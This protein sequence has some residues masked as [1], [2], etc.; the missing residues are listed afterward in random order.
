MRR[1]S[2]N[3]AHTARMTRMS[4]AILKFPGA[5][6]A[7]RTLAVVLATLHTQAD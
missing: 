1:L 6:T 5:C 7:M 2:R 3:P 4:V